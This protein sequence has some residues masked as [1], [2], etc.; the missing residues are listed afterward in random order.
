MM[1]AH[2]TR[3]PRRTPVFLSPK[4]PQLENTLPKAC[5]LAAQFPRTCREAVYLF[6]SG[7]ILT[8]P[9]SPYQKQTRSS[10]APFHH[11]PLYVAPLLTSGKAGSSTDASHV[12][13]CRIGARPR[14]A[15]AL[16]PHIIKP[17]LSKARALFQTR[18]C[19][20]ATTK[21]PAKP[22]L[23]ICQHFRSVQS[24]ARA[25]TDEDPLFLDVFRTQNNCHPSYANKQHRLKMSHL[26]PTSSSS[27]A[28]CHS[29]LSY[30]T[31]KTTTHAL[32]DTERTNLQL[33]GFK[34]KIKAL[35]SNRA[36]F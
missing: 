22:D 17:A 9:H 19:Q 6:T 16:F 24:S 12:A 3:V 5:S 26:T 21:H 34:C 35:S 4:L 36:R 10:R 33:S 13:A 25:R 31:T 29:S 32:H 8:T 20:V 18:P 27:A 23:F 7:E 2:I 30:P 28:K 11:A 14:E 1:R 15:E